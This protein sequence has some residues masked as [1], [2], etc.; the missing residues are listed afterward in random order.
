MTFAH[1]DRPHY[2]IEAQ[3]Y[4]DG[5]SHKQIEELSI[6]SAAICI[7]P[8]YRTFTVYVTYQV[9][10]TFMV[11]PSGGYDEVPDEPVR[12]LKGLGVINRSLVVLYK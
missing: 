11:S 4:H 9:L 7:L 6:S 2:P 3:Q 10:D 5:P 1:Q 8:S 12:L